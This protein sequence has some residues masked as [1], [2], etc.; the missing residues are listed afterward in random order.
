MSAPLLQWVPIARIGRPKGL[1]GHFFC[2]PFNSQSVLFDTIE[3]VAVAKT[4]SP[5]NML[6]LD[7]CYS[8]F[9]GKR[10]VLKFDQMNQ[11]SEV[12]RF[13]NHILF[14]RRSDFQSL[15]EHEYYHVDLLGL[16]VQ[17]ENGNE[18][19]KV[20]Q[21]I[22]TPAN[23]ILEIS[24]GEKMYMAAFIKQFIVSVSLK[25]QLI[26]YKKDGVVDAL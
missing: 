1:K 6:E 17:D 24:S 14:A 15:A 16:L 21:V 12:E 25:D 18:L 7:L 4:E 9:N 20:T 13:T 5:E 23:D 11:I 22:S 2:D 3:H 8:H 10:W 26:V 19:G